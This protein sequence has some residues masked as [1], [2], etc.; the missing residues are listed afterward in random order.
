G[1]RLV[2]AELV[3]D[4]DGRRVHRSPEIRHG[5][6][7]HLVEPVLINRSH[8]ISLVSWTVG[9]R[10]A[11]SLAAALHP[12]CK[13][14]ASRPSHHRSMTTTTTTTA[15]DRLLEL[16]AHT[17]DPDV[18]ATFATGAVIDATVP[19]WRFSIE[20]AERIGYQLAEWFRFPGT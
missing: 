13:T 15:A 3:A 5:L 18:T 1:E 17:A 10:C 6:A 16:A 4:H 7:D 14:P 11:S 9:R 2:E 20:S 8:R 19:G 12:V